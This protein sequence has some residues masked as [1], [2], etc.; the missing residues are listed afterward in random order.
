MSTNKKKIKSR[1]KENPLL[2]KEK[3]QTDQPWCIDENFKTLQ[4]GIMRQNRF[5]PRRITYN[6]LNC[7]KPLS[8]FQLFKHCQ[9]ENLLNTS[10]LKI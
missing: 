2:E 8:S 10:N 9:V 1:C 6:E 7:L 5:L 4:N 3:R